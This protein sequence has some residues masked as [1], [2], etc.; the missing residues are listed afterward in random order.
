MSFFQVL[1]HNAA[2][3]AR[4]GK[5]ITSH[6]EIPTPAFLPIGTLG[7]I[8]AVSNSDLEAIGYKIFL[9]NTYHLYL[10]P[11][12]E[13]LA[14]A[15]G[16]HKFI[17]WN[18][19]IL[20][21]SGGF[22]LY[23]LA[24]L[25]KF[26]GDGIKFSSHIDGSTHFF[27]P[28]DIIDIQRVIGSDIIMP[29]DVCSEFPVS[30]SD[31]EAALNITHDWEKRC[32]ERFKLNKSEFEGKQYL[33]SINQGSVFKDLRKRSIEFLNELDFD[34]NAI[35]GLAVGEENEIMYEIV[36]FCTDILPF[37]KPRYLMGVGTPE[38][39][40]NVVEM[41]I[42]MFDCVIPTRNARHGR[43]YSFYGE[44]NIK[45]SVNKYNFDHID[46]G[47]DSTVLKIH[48]L[49][50]LRHLFATNEPLAMRLATIHNLEFY[51]EFMNRIRCSIEQNKFAEFKKEFLNNYMNSK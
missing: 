13:I 45:S 39:I 49:S 17:N 47:F 4:T 18:Y 23:S 20:T 27:T 46:V 29:L 22:Q 11:G 19:S 10:R 14:N 41:G 3:K 37:E 34:G 50:Y 38:N 40:L 44:I 16:L 31:A 21:D 24:S 26:N 32:L 43:L 8:K 9:A 7:S 35:G 15:G 1:C 30:K 33:F 36:D 5:I 12:T 51:F 25:R 28:E 42:D 48:S 2:L 6:S